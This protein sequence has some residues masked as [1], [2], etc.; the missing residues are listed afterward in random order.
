MLEAIILD[1]HPLSLVCQRRGKAEADACREWLLQC[2]SAGLRIHVPE[3]A[4]YE[5]RRELLRAGKSAAVVRLDRFSASV[6]GRYLP[7]TTPAMRRA[8]ELWAE[9]RQGGV[10]TADTQALDGGC[11]L[12]G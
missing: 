2:I 12:G 3:V 7:I 6:P 9:A 8:A 10:P 4:D 11:P 5:L 1:T